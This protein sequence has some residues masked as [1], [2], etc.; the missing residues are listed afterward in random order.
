MLYNKSVGGNTASC[1]LAT[2]GLTVH[3]IVQ[4]KAYVLWSL[5]LNEH[6]ADLTDVR[7]HREMTGSRDLTY[8]DNYVRLVSRHNHR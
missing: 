1:G 2:Y 6:L 4:L 5:V 8:F 3:Q 7:V